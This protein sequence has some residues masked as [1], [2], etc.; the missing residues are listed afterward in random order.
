VGT[1]LIDTDVL[2]KTAAYGL[3]HGLLDSHPWGTDCFLMLGAALFMVKKKLKKRPPARGAAAAIDEFEA[4]LMSATT[5]EPSSDEVLF[6]ANL[7]HAA[8]QHNVELDQGESLLCAVLLYRGG[9]YIFSGDK[10]AIVALQSLLGLE[11]ISVEIRP[12]KQRLVCL[13]QLFLLLLE[14]LEC[15]R[16]RSAVCAEPN[17]DKALSNC[18]NC[19]SL[20]ATIESWRDG[21][22]SYIRSLKEQAPD[23][24]TC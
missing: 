19:C 24:L 15:G 2:Y 5:I 11:S 3:L 22:N 23:V 9:D 10:R 20:N 6:A 7:E 13:E 21:L 17:V 8:Q 4:A 16:V 12:I 18:F 14:N 1:A